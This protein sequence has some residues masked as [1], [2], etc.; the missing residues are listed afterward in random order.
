MQIDSRKRIFGLDLMRAIAIVLVVFSHIT[1]ILP[2]AHGFIPDLM[3]VAGVLGVELF[4]VL[5]GFLIGRIIYKL[6]LSSDFGFKSVLHFWVR[7]W[8]RTLPNYYLA[9]IL[10]IVIAIYIGLSLPDNL[11]RYFIFLQNFNSEMP[12]LFIESWS[13]SIEEFAYILGPL[14]L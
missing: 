5:S 12:F 14:L 11:F 2:N 1:W 6:F 10:N 9:L 4:F 13:L 3:S 7:R 8:F